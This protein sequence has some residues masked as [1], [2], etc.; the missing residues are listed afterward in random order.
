[1]DSIVYLIL[2]YFVLSVVDIATTLT[3]FKRGGYERNQVMNRVGCWMGSLM[4]GVLTVKLATLFLPAA[5]IWVLVQ[6]GESQIAY[7]LGVGIVALV[8]AVIAN[9]ILVLRKLS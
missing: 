7:W 8:A 4:R 3:I 5:G 1:M 2:L 9:N 6:Y